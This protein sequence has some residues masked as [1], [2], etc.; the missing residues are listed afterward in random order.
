[1]FNY[2]IKTKQENP[3]LARHITNPRFGFAHTNDTSKVLMYIYVHMCTHIHTHP[4]FGF[5]HT[6][7]SSKGY[8]HTHTPSL[9]VP[10]H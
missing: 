1:M 7:V 9:R 5:A 10:E 6:H 8:T 3:N 4:R 2:N